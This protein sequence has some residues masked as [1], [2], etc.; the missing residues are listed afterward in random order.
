MEMRFDEYIQ[1]KALELKATI[2]GK[3]GGVARLLGD[4]GLEKMGMKNMCF[5]VDPVTQARFEATIGA[6]D[7]SKQEA[8]TEM[9]WEMLDR[10]DAQLEQV[11]LGAINYDKR[12]AELG[13]ELSDPDENGNRSL[14]RIDQPKDE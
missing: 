6:L 9:L 5:R 2:A 3:G 7:I 11:G 13:F 8:L 12:L 1:M 10:I 14:K 4:E